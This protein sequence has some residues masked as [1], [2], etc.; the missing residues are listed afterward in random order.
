MDDPDPA[1]PEQ[2]F[3]NDPDIDRVNGVVWALATEL[4][5]LRDRVSALEKALAESG[6]IDLDA[7]QRE[8]TVEEAAQMAADRQAFVDHLFVNMTGLQQSKGA[9]R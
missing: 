1:R 4:F 2:T 6:A 5:V 3:F 8:P 9:P 7:L